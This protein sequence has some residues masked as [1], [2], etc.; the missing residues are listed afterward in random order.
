LAS[1]PRGYFEAYQEGNCGDKHDLWEVVMSLIP[2]WDTVA[3]T[4]GWSNFYF[5]ASIVA[6]IL[7]GVFEVV[8]HRYAERHDDL[9]AIERENTDNTYNRQI[10]ELHR[11]AA[12]LTAEAAASRA[13]IAEAQA[14]AAEAQLE[15]AK[16]RAPRSLN[17][18]QRRRFADKLTPFAGTPCVIFVQMTPDPIG[19]HASID[20]ALRLAG[21]VPTWP[22]S[23]WPVANLVGK[24]VGIAISRGTQVRY[25]GKDEHIVPIARALSEALSE[26]GINNALDDEESAFPHAVV[27]QIGERE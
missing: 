10:A 3:G 11:D 16:F 5:W 15:L 23:P 27:L 8:S 14:R 18:S 12:K 4:H 22:N 19:L 26:A 25:D 2:G 6:L 13:Q 17:E 7:L 9:V 21:W 24:T 20:T 1:R